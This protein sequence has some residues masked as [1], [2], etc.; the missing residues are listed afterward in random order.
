MSDRNQNINP[1]RYKF[2]PRVLIFSTHD[3]KL[4]L[5]KGSPTKKLWPNLFNGI[6]GHI[7]Q[8]ENILSAAKR[9]YLE[10]TGLELLDPQLRAIVTID[11]GQA[12]GICMFVFTGSA[13][14][15]ALLS[16]SEGTLHWIDP[17]SIKSLPLV[18]DLE[19]LIPK[20]LTRDKNDPIL[21]AHYWYNE[22]GSLLIDFNEGN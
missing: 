22:N 11:T 4:L 8:G 10:E 19:T 17:I 5:I 6:G 3:D 1:D 14:E 15:G 12:V 13:G 21:Y 7:E 2:I 20:V 18:E 16:S 9:E